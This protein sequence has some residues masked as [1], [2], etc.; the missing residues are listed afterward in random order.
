MGDIRPSTP[1]LEK[2][3][4]VPLPKVVGEAR[5]MTREKLQENNSSLMDKC[6][7]V[8]TNVRHRGIQDGPDSA[9]VRSVRIGR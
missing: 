5:R 6:P 7:D 8:Q 9:I 4:Y 3:L 1:L 2:F